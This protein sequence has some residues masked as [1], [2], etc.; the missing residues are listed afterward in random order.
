MVVERVNTEEFDKILAEEKRY[1]I[2]D[3]WAPW[4]GPCKSISPYFE[5][6]S[7]KFSDKMRFLS[8]NVDEEPDIPQRYMISSIP[9]F[10]IFKNGKPHQS[11]MGNS[12]KKLLK[13][14]EETLEE[15]D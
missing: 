8:I 4:C 9:T 1:V 7:N 15:D 13:L 11:M 2:I 5:V 3:T 14:I 6:L 12:R 10:I